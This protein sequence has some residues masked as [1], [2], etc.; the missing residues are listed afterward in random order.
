MCVTAE[1]AT[2]MSAREVRATPKSC[3]KSGR[4]LCGSCR[5]STSLVLLMAL[6]QLML[7]WLASQEGVTTQLDDG[8]LRQGASPKEPIDLRKAENQDQK[9]S[10]SQQTKAKRRFARRAKLPGALPEFSAPIG[11]VTAVVGRDVRLVCTVEHL[12]QYQVSLSEPFL[13]LLAS[14]SLLAHLGWLSSR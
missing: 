2:I 8:S 14:G 1:N 6:F 11:N 10:I 9:A 5:R 12:G 4:S 13:G 7:L 3:L